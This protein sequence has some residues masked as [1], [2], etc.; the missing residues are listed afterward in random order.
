MSLNKTKGNMYGF[1]DHTWNTVKGKC[2]HH[3]AY[4]YMKRWGEQKPVR[5]DEKELNTDLGEGNYIFIGS[6]CD[7]FAEDIEKEW[8]LDTLKKANQYKNNY[9]AQS[10]NP[11]RFHHFLDEL[12]AEKFMLCTTIETNRNYPAIMGNSP[13]IP[14][15]VVAMCR[16]PRQY[17]KRKMVTVEPIIKF[18]L[19]EL[20]YDI[21][22]I[23]PVQ[24]NIGADSGNNDLP[25]P[26][27]K[28]VERLIEILERYTKVL[29]KPNLE[30]LL[31]E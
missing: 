8:I 7:L 28:E 4:C 25:E 21:L 22:C 13:E 11:V 12:P 31:R 9:L 5:F 17:Q 15:R 14:S 18:D 30:R 29:K 24:V 2:S 23:N 27:K 1:I 3:C 6:S 10:K 20:S 19:K 16:L 26:T